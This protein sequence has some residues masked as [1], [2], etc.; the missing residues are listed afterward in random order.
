M[1]RGRRSQDWNHLKAPIVLCKPLS[2]TSCDGDLLFCS[3]QTQMLNQTIVVSLGRWQATKKDASNSLQKT[4]PR[5]KDFDSSQLSLEASSQLHSIHQSFWLTPSQ[6]AKPT[7]LHEP[8]A[9]K[10]PCKQEA[11]LQL[12]HME[13]FSGLQSSRGP[14]YLWQPH[15]MAPNVF[16]IFLSPKHNIHS[17]SNYNS[18]LW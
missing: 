5:V 14:L 6:N 3:L 13:K 17:K 1:L 15:H 11:A 8:R 9:R 18:R 4:M 2:T 12:T 16:P 10:S 7:P